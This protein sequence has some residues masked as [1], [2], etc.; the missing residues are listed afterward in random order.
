MRITPSVRTT[1]IKRQVAHEADIYDPSQFATNPNITTPNMPR[2]FFAS[3]VIGDITLVNG[4]VVKGTYAGG[5]RPIRARP[6][7]VSGE[8]ITDITRISIREH[9]FEILNS[10]GT[11]GTIMAVVSPV[12]HAPR[13]PHACSNRESAARGRAASRGATL[14]PTDA[15]SGYRSVRV[16]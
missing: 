8:A 11:I 9:V 1:T 14:V 10:H 5:V 12:P 2:N 15:S 16:E 3:P 13:I 4:E 7:P 6:N